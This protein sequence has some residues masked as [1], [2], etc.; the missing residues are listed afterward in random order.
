MLC[1]R[2][3]ERIVWTDGVQNEVLHKSQGGSEH[4]T[5]KKEKE[6]YWIREMLHRNFLLKHVIKVRWME[7]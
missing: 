1:W 3:V 7:G 2:R 4:P 6:S 5:Y